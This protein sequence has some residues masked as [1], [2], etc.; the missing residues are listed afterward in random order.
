MS[1]TQGRGGKQ[2]GWDPRN[3]MPGP[4]GEVVGPTL[5]GCYGSWRK[6]S[7]S[8]RCRN[9]REGKEEKQDFC[10]GYGS[11]IELLPCTHKDLGPIPNATNKEKKMKRKRRRRK[12]IRKQ[13]F[14][15]NGIKKKSK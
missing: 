8:E 12:N 5:L 9:L 13:E 14:F 6:E 2:R 11:V 4:K 3:Y 7:V 1:L 10:L 15:L